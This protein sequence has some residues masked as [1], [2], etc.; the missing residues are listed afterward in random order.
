MLLKGVL[1]DALSLGANIDFS[2]IQNALDHFEY[3]EQTA[4][5]QRLARIQEADIVFSNKVVLDRAILAQCPNLK[6]IV[7]M[8]TGMNN[9]D[10]AYAAERN[11]TVRNAVAYGT[12][13]VA[14]HSLML[15]L[16]LA[17]Q[18]LR[19][20]KSLD[21][22][23]WQKSPYFCLMSH[24]VIELAGKHLV[25]VGAGALGQ[26]VAQLAEAFDMQ[27]SFSARAQLHAPKAEGDG[28]PSLDELLPQADFLSLH[29][30]LTA[31][32]ENL[33]NAERLAKAKPGLMLV[34]C[35]RGGIV[36]EADALAALRSGQLGGL[37]T[38]VLSAE[39]PVNGNLLLEARSEDLNLIVT[40]HNA[41][42]SQS[43]RQNIVN[44]AAHSVLA[45]RNTIAT[46]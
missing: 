15:M 27:V 30:P 6:L 45:Y 39:P 46:L 21:A 42:I 40:P 37:A 7:V 29:C 36:N 41:W 14:Q 31:E 10:L 22:D 20:Q 26:K 8:A 35:A 32:T 43:A 16:M 28:R 12:N 4:P 5:E 44:Q 17:T 19:Y 24:S 9:I 2:G 3:Y 38:D 33:I 1:L 11:I 23:Q 18:Q 25:I 34:N 13:S